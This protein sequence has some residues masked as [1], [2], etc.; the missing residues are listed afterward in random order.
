ML[1]QNYKKELLE[2][3]SNLNKQLQLA[4]LDLLAT[5]QPEDIYPKTTRYL[6]LFPFLPYMI[7][8]LLFSTQDTQLLPQIPLHFLLADLPTH[9][10][11][12]FLPTHILL[13]RTRS[14][15]LIRPHTLPRTHLLP[16]SLLILQPSIF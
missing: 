6:S 2:M 12:P 4:F 13:L 14:R 15:L 1:A 7:T 5:K 11:S 16:A 8:Y 3:K 10:L 9:D